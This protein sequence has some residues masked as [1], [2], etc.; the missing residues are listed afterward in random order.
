M[1]RRKPPKKEK[2]KPK[3]KEKTKV[4]KKIVKKPELTLKEPVE[5]PKEVVEDTPEE[6]IEEVVEVLP[7]PVPIFEVSSLPRFVHRSSP[8]YPP[9][10]RQQG[11]EGKVLIEALVD[12]T[13]KVR[14]VDV[15][16][17]AGVLFDAAAVAAIQGSTFIPAHTNGKPVPVL[18][19]V[20][21]H[22]RLR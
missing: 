17:S 8:I 11:K 19:R 21:I 1:Q 7:T 10:M 22:F 5:T 9:S 14:K 13:G 16:Q 18:L 6:V 2:P 12:K 3:K 20:P 4:K 15:I